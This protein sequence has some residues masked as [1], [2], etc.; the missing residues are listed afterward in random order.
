MNLNE[1][2]TAVSNKLPIVTVLLDNNALGMVRQWQTMFYGGRYSE[3]TLSRRTDYVKLAE[4][5][6]AKG[7]GAETPEELTNALNAARDAGGPVLI[8]CAVDADENVF[9]MIP[10]GGT[11]SDIIIR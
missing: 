2:A 5:F 1:L 11:V 3:T 7:F 8:R 9:P 6:G 10:P 4:A